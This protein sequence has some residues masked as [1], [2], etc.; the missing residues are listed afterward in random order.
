MKKA[1]FG[2]LLIPLLAAVASGGQN[3]EAKVYIDFD[4]PNMV[5]S[6]YPDSGDFVSGCLI[7]DCMGIAS[8]YTGGVTEIC[9]RVDATPGTATSLGGTSLLPGGIE[10]GDWQ[11]GICLPTP[12][13]QYPDGSTPGGII[14]VA[15]IGLY[16][17]G[18]PGDLMIEYHPDYPGGHLVDCNYDVDDFCIWAW[19]GVGKSCTVVTPSCGTCWPATAAP[20]EPSSWG[21]IKAL[22]K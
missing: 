21:T 14:K 3:L 22:Y 17:G 11:T 13:C 1:C 20:G 6:V 7:L 19:G 5:Q 12:Y 18:V 10:I 9:F 16:Y 15:V 2:I 8:P 4:P